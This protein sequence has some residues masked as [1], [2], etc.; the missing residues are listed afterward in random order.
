VELLERDWALTHLVDARESATRGR[1]RV[2]VV[3]G[4][5]G[6]GKTWL[7][8]QFLEDVGKDS[9][10]LFGTCD[11]LTIPRPL[12]PIRDLAGSV[13]E[14][15]ATALSRGAAAHDIQALLI[16][17][18]ETQPPPTVL[19]IE[20]VHWADDATLDLITVLGRRIGS[21]P[22]LLVLTFRA[23]EAPP[24][25]RLHATV[26]SIRA[27]DTVV[28]ELPPLSERA[29]TALAGHGAD[30]VYAATGGNPFYVTEMLAARDAVELP[31]SVA[32]AVLGRASRLDEAARHLVELVAIVPSRVS[33]SLLDA[34][35][36][37]WAKA[38]EE[39]ERRQ[40]LEVDPAYVRFR[41][42]L[43]RHA[44]EANIPIAAQ[45]RL[46]AEILTALLNAHGDPSDIVHHAE[47]AGAV[48]VVADYALV[49]A[50]RASALESNRE[51]YFHY[52][53]A[54][55]FV[56]RRSLA[57]QATVLE[58]LSVAAYVVNR[59]DEAFAPLERAIEINRDLDQGV[60]VGRCMR[61]L[62]R[63]HWFA[64]NGEEAKTTALESIA[65]LEPLGESG[66]LAYAY[67]G[68]SQ[69]SMLADDVEQALLWGTRALDLATRL[70]DEVTRAHAL[71]NVGA[72][73]ML[74]DADVIE[75]LLEAHDTAHAAGDPYE[76][77]RSLINIGYTLICFARPDQAS[78]YAH[79]ALE[80]AVEHEVHNLASYA[81]TM[82]AWLQL[83]AGQWDEAERLVRAE[84]EK[85]I[86]VLQLSAKTVLTE[87]AV[88]RGDA[89]AAD[90]LADLIEQANHTREPQ[91]ISPVVELM[92]EFAITS[93]TPVPVV[94]LKGLAGRIRPTNGVTIWGLR[95][96]AWAA[97]AGIDVGLELP[98]GGPF[99]AMAN[100][101]WRAAA[102]A[103]G[104]VGWTYDRAFMLSMLDDEASLV[105]A[106]EI[107]RGLG[108][109]PLTKHIAR[110]LRDIGV[111]VPPGQREATRSNSAGLT[112]R[113]LE[114]LS[115][116]AAGLTNVAIAERLIVS[117]RTAEH[118]VAAILTK[119]GVTT[120]GDAAR[121]AA[122]LGMVTPT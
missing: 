35:M 113:Q 30:K 39:P 9:T 56:H 78:H 29:V 17:E 59:I 27:E 15:L 24:G 12:G 114:V 26:G 80:Y 62:S 13:S 120:R 7:V 52:R 25:H 81:S 91:R 89:D 51:A 108:A 79:R 55:A 99:G 84:V 22:A 100:R 65:V 49:A 121:R 20:D 87:L 73:R 31:P 77:T 102:D 19:V 47:S 107:T 21:L 98:A 88:R 53:R 103:F 10:V 116:L 74:V 14:A 44:I 96:I 37:D 71:V 2:V 70:G 117:Q 119:L 72:A 104:A 109:A 41:H 122:Q 42:E 40:L 38:A 8:K 36:P 61:V 45:R 23:G 18:L 106:I 75:E 85:G 94:E 101:D 105:E 97:A 11:D 82:I 46:H 33:T 112:A 63:I 90:R 118:H 93:G 58:E 115:L 60:A 67:S 28:V 76:A 68:M 64:G 95:T 83:R 110:R 5:P 66:Q 92:T 1:G 4:E 43:A 111:R 6:I 34:V 32:N 69:L 86:T 48:D 3:T 16:E 50:R 57:E 54:A